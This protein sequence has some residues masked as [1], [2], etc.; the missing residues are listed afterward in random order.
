MN[1]ILKSLKL[2]LLVQQPP[3]PQQL[4]QQQQPQVSLIVNVKLFLF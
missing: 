2:K 3:L 4:L 1:S